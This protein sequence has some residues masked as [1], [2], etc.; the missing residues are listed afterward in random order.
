MRRD[1]LISLKKIRVYEVA[2]EKNERSSSCGIA[3]ALIRFSRCRYGVLLRPG[4]DRPLSGHGG[5]LCQDLKW[6]R[7]THYLDRDIRLV[8]VVVVGSKY[9][10]VSINKVFYEK[11]G[12]EKAELA[13]A[14][15]IDITTPAEQEK[16]K[17]LLIEAAKDKDA[18]YNSELRFVARNG[19]TVRTKVTVTAAGGQSKTA[20][21]LVTVEDFVQTR[22]RK[23][24]TH[25][26]RLIRV[27]E[28]AE[29]FLHELR[30]Q[31]HGISLL[32]RII[33]QESTRRDLLEDDPLMILQQELRLRLKDVGT[34]LQDLSHLG[35]SMKLK[36]QPTDLAELVTR[37][38]SSDQACHIAEQI[39]IDCDIAADVP[40]IQLDRRRFKQ[41]WLNLFK[42]AVE[43]MP[44][45]G[46][47][48]VRLYRSNAYVCL[49]IADTGTG[50]PDGIDIFEPFTTTKPHGTGLGLG[51]VREIVSAHGGIVSYQ[52][53]PQSG[54][55]FTVSLPSVA[56]GGDCRKS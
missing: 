22:A 24:S 45:G 40:L 4:D 42:N 26:E 8:G 25:T 38:L 27:E 10:I 37:L 41:A 31:M 14:S 43:A 39:R 54:A 23:T 7:S 51:I 16:C 2:P 32:T 50:V 3:L 13:G 30:N 48:T 47:I 46:T 21:I 12:Y 33:E 34:L 9:E 1:A 28:S 35:E 55:S 19:E 29:I 49:E 6:G 18:A 44:S 56:V 5:S 17:R 20:N 11:I 53:T 36:L 52:S 15:L